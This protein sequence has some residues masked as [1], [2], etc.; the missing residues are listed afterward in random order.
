MKRIVLFFYLIFTLNGILS[1][2]SLRPH[3]SYPFTQIRP[4]PPNM[5]YAEFLKLER[6]L[7][8]KK[9]TEAVALPG[10]IHFYAGHHKMAWTILGIRSLGFLLSG[11]G[12]LDQMNHWNEPGGWFSE[13]S[14]TTSRSK[15]NMYLFVSGM[16]LNVFG[17]A[18]DWAHGDFVIERERNTVLYKYGIERNWPPRLSFGYQTKSKTLR[19][20]LTFNF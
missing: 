10:Y 8:W 1:A 4:L 7:D 5:T 14:T 9:I 12:I 13:G 16:A 11:I 6:Q 19:L 15:R 3:T 20:F 18:F 2:Q 17:F